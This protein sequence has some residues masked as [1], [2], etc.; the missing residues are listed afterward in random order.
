MKRRDFLQASAALPAVV[1]ADRLSVSAAGTAD[2]NPEQIS[3]AAQSQ[4]D[5]AGMNV[6]VFITDQQRAIQH[7]PEGWAEANLPAATQLQQTGV[8]FENAFCNACMCSPSRATLLTGRFPAQHGVKY[9]LEANMPDDEYPQVPLPLD[10]ANIGTVM[11]AAGFNTP[12]KGKWHVSKPAGSDWTTDDLAQYGFQRWDAPDAGANQDLDQMGGGVADNDG[13]FMEEEGPAEEGQEGVLDFL[14]SE[15]AQQQPFFLIV[16]LVNPHDVLTYPKNYIEGGYDD[17]ALVG[18][19]DLPQ[20]IDESL[21]TKPTAQEAILQ[22]ANQGLGELTTPEQQRNYLNFYGNLMKESDTYL[23]DILNALT[24][25]GLLENT[26]IVA[27]SDHGEMGLAHGGMRQKSFNVYEETLNV[28]LV[29]SNPKLFP[30][31]R[32]SQALVSHVDFLPTMAGLFNAPEDA[33]SDWQGVDYSALLLDPAAE[34]AQDYVVFT[35]DDIQNGQPNGPY[36]PPPN[37]IT[38]IREERYKLAKY[39]DV[40]GVEPD[41]WE[42]YDLLEDPLETV[43][44]AYADY[45]RTPEQELELER[46]L[47][48]LTEIE[49][50]RLAPLPN[51]PM[52]QATPAPPVPVATP[53]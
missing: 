36:V 34:P 33:R 20:T 35:F 23:M 39:Y 40:N 17:T 27:T 31:A 32:T 38:S 13:R 29:Y 46:L 25:Q 28:P 6:V 4:A 43:N 2:Q 50:T 1:V 47:A 42:M 16:S 9:T 51:T 15:A 30:E 3:R 52:P 18:D 41:Q 12:Y 37:H 48:R 22:L 49:S 19:I 14:T 8:T 53:V 21:A 45:E 24:N 26:L 44:L 7:F 11:G 10:I 5:L